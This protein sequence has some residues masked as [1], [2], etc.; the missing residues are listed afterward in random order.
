M[1]RYLPILGLLVACSD[2][3]KCGIGDAPATL[4]ATSTAA[5]AVTMT[6]ASL[7][8]SPNGDCPDHATPGVISLTIETPPGDDII[9]LCVGRPDKLGGGLPFGTDAATTIQLVD[10]DGTDASSCTYSIDRNAPITG[11]AQADGLC[12]NGTDAAGFALT[13]DATLSLS[14]KCGT[15]TTSVPFALSGTVAVAGP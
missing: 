6:F 7:S 11:T 2:P 8:G 1:R 5:P 3:P 10:L 13:L 15:V 14:Q 12:S 4:A 9:T